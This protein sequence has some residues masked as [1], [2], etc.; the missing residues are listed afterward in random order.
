MLIEPYRKQVIRSMVPHGVTKLLDVGCGPVFPSYPYADLAQSV[1]CVDWNLKAIGDIPANITCINGDF[2]DVELSAESFDTV[3]AADVFEHIPL[4]RETAFLNKCAA[5]LRPG[6]TLII[7][8]PHRGTWA[9]LDV[10]NVKPVVHYAL[11][12]L[13]LRRETHNGHC[14]IRKGHKHYTLDELTLLCSPLKHVEHRYWG[15][16]YDPL[17]TWADAL[18]RKLGRFPGRD[19]LHRKAIAE[20]GRDFA[21]RSFNIAVKLIK[22]KLSA[23]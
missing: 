10:Y 16:L 17:D 14:D 3:I 15:F 18:V 21:D 5:M 1:T 13:G 9:F 2:I 7:S 22:E 6:G 11:W 20:Y 8:V 23:N 19:T 4:E 12:R